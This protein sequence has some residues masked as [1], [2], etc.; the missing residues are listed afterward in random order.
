MLKALTAWLYLSWELVKILC[1]WTQTVFICYIFTGEKNG[2]LKAESYGD[3]RCMCTVLIMYN[4]VCKDKR[5]AGHVGC[6]WETPNSEKPEWRWLPAGS[7]LHRVTYLRPPS[8]WAGAHLVLLTPAAAIFLHLHLPIFSVAS[9]REVEGIGS[10]FSTESPENAERRQREERA[11]PADARPRYCHERPSCRQ[12]FCAER[13]WH[14]SRKKHSVFQTLFGSCNNQSVWGSGGIL[15][16]SGR[17]YYLVYFFQG[18]ADG[19]VNHP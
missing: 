6:P 4:Y 12:Q 7:Q 10:V 16:C 19:Q 18:Q 1:D 8:Q 5:K 11:N 2:T 14:Q 13:G 15:S 3:E 9:V 17:I